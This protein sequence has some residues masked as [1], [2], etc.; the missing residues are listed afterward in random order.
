MCIYMLTSALAFSAIVNAAAT[1]SIIGKNEW[2]E[3]SNINKE[4][5][6]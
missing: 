6:Y 2:N 1:K 3:V 4:N 5:H